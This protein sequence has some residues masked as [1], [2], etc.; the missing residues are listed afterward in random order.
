[1]NS[2]ALRIVLLV[3]CAHALVHVYELALPATEQSIAADFHVTEKI[4]G[5]LGNVWRLPFGLG[6]LA[7]GWL[8]DRYGSKPLLVVY[9]LGC[10]AMSLATWVTTEISLLFV[11]MFSMGCFASIYH[12]AGLAIISRTTRPDQRPW[13]L[14]LHGVFGSIGIA[15]SP[16]M[17]GLALDMGATWRDCYLWL[18]L[19]GGLLAAVL[20]RSL[21]EQ[22]SVPSSEV[23][24]VEIHEPE[25][26]LHWIP[27][28]ILTSSGALTGFVYAG[29]L[30]FLPRYLSEAW[31]SLSVAP[32]AAQPVAVGAW[33]A[34]GV[35][36]I[37]IIGQ[38]MAGWYA[39]GRSLERVLAIVLSA[40]V[41]LLVWMSQAEG[42]ARIVSAGL[43]S[44]VLFMHQPVYNSLVAKYIPHHRRSL[45]YGFS[46]VLTFGVGS[47]GAGSMGLLLEQGGIATAYVTLAVCAAIGTSL[48]IGLDWNQRLKAFSR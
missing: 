32:S 11:T 13:A 21:V 3:S 4:T 19:P 14:G 7:A 30:Q 44:L 31:A 25:D 26:T 43:L 18:S 47:F 16:A 37:G 36:L 9:L 41:P 28:L 12:P 33:L 10:A 1:M 8:A 15:A 23:S 24:H 20:Y 2:A 22:R 5:L 34:S 39:R 48:A 35:L 29:V 40:N 42:A 46:N 17:V 38:L 45:G 27:F 6:A